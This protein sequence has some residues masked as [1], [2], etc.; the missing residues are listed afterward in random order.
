MAEQAPG[1]KKPRRRGAFKGAEKLA[2]G[3]DVAN[4]PRTTA[5]PTGLNSMIEITADF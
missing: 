3:A 4:P 1:K 2:L 5:N